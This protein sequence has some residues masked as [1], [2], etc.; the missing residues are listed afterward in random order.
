MVDGTDE[1]LEVIEKK[2]KQLEDSKSELIDR[3]RYMTRRVRLKKYEQKALEPYLKQT[4]DVQI[5]PLRKRRNRVEFM[6]A[7]A[8]Y[9]PR[10][11]RE[12]LKEVRRLDSELAKVREIERARRKKVLV[13]RDVVDGQKE[14]DD[15]EKSLKDARDSLRRLYDEAKSVRMAARRSVAAAA[16]AEEDMV[17]L[18]D[19][20][21]IERKG[22]KE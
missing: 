16:F 7:T 3:I 20:A 4:E 5:T 10:M 15:I 6:I 21:M 13:D 1:Q 18:G 8:A 11:E 2:I 9:T 19:L 22:K 12:W 14:I 17:A